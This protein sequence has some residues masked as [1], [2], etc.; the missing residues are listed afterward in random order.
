MAHHFQPFHH[1]YATE[2]DLLLGFVDI[3]HKDHSRANAFQKHF[4]AIFPHYGAVN[5]EQL[6]SVFIYFG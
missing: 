4:I 6:H 1:L 2:I 3:L 5:V